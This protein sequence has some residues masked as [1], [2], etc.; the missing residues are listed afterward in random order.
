MEGW[1]DGGMETW[2]SFGSVSLGI[3]LVSDCLYWLEYHLACKQAAECRQRNVFCFWC[4]SL[5]F[6]DVFWI[7][8]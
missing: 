7:E 6:F 2:L 5:T 4:L 3:F 1:R 8:V